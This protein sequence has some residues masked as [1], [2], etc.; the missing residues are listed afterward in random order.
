MSFNDN[1]ANTLG[2]NDTSAPRV[3]F[4]TAPNAFTAGLTAIDLSGNALTFTHPEADARPVDVTVS[5]EW[6]LDLTT[7]HDSGD[8]VS[9]RTLTISAVRNTPQPGTTT[10]TA[11][12][13]GA[14]A[15]RIFVRAVTIRN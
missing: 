3:L 7:W 8:T 2:T 5:Y 6:S 10:V 14:E 4:T 13:T 9:D 15:A 11:A 1:D 12:L